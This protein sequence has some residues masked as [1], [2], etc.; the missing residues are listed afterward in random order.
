MMVLFHALSCHAMSYITSFCSLSCPLPLYHITYHVISCAGVGWLEQDNC[1]V[2]LIYFWH[3]KEWYESR[4]TLVLPPDYGSL[5]DS[6]FLCVGCDCHQYAAAWF[7]PWQSYSPIFPLK[8]EQYF[9]VAL[10]ISMSWCTE[11]QRNRRQ[12]ST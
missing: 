6:L 5:Y 12:L 1:L 9:S 11:V 7:R 10:T 8:C 2:F 4:Q 3:I